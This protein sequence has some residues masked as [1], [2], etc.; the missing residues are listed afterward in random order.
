MLLCLYRYHIVSFETH[1]LG[2]GSTHVFGL[3]VVIIRKD[4]LLRLRY[5]GMLRRVV[6]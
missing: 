1:V 6:W 4:F 5:S 2:I 3:L